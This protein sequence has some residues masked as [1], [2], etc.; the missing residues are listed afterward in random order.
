MYRNILAPTDGSELSKK[1]VMEAARLAKFSGAS[2]LLLHVRSPIEVPHHVAGGAL[3]RF[4]E[5]KLME[6]IAVEERELLDAAVAI[7][8]SA[9]IEAEVAFIAGYSP[10]ESI[11]RVAQERHCDLIVMASRIRHGIP[12]FVIQSE[13]H[14]VLMHSDIPVLVMR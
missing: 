13:T 1:A 11:I 6:E 9:G 7:A 4:G 5:V 14:K 3:S 12:S 8:A 10:Y 2:L